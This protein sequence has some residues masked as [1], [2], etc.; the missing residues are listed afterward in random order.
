MSEKVNITSFKGVNVNLRA[1]L[2]EDNQ[3][4]DMANLRF[5]RLG[6]LVNR[7]GSI[8]YNI[9]DSISAQPE[10]LD[11]RGCVAIGEFILVEADNDST[12]LGGFGTDRFMVYALRRSATLAGSDKHSMV[13]VMVPLTGAYKNRLTSGIYAKAFTVRDSADGQRGSDLFQAP[14][15]RLENL[16]EW[17]DE[18][19]VI[20]DQNWIE[21]YGKMNQYRDMLIISDKV[22]GDMLL[23]DK[24]NEM[25]QNETKKHE[26]HL[27][28]NGKAAFDID[29]VTVDYGLNAG[30]FN[31]AGVKHG[32]ALYRY[33]L[34]GKMH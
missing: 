34:P 8:A 6:A 32:M 11:A 3:A 14:D 2:I 24:F 4:S 19:G 10:G 5:N 33:Y 23:A 7:N 21:H 18:K 16:D 26:F 1:D 9:P 31:A 25:G 20:Y 28:D 13:Y 29:A 15:R 22:N 12:P 30:G 27:R 17:Q